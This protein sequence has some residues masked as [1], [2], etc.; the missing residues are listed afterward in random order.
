M[1][2][3]G[4]AGSIEEEKEERERR[5]LEE[6]AKDPHEKKPRAGLTSWIWEKKKA[7]RNGR[8]AE[9]LSGTRWVSFDS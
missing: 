5:T 1:R 3:G 9:K 7:K 8:D 4:S 2:R 6:A